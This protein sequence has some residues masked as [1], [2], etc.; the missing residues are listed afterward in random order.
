[1][2]LA[3]ISAALFPPL[4]LMALLLLLV[5]Q[6]AITAWPL[7]SLLSCLTRLMPATSGIRTFKTALCAADGS[8]PMSPL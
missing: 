5:K 8:P 6:E 2:L 3:V 4:E 1:M 7:L